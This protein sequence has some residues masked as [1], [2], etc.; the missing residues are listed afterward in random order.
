[1]TS[2]FS[3]IFLLHTNR[4]KFPQTLKD[5]THKQIKPCQPSLFYFLAH[6][7]A[8][9][10]EE[11]VVTSQLPDPVL[12]SVLLRASSVALE[13]LEH[14]LLSEKPSYSNLS[15]SPPS[16]VS[17]QI[18]FCYQYFAIFLTISPSLPTLRSQC[19]PDTMLSLDFFS[20]SLKMFSHV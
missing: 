12:F 13:A 15:T 19:L 1:M 18:T 4:S 16:S 9:I 6:H 17:P 10:L 11:V 7:W 5:K 2:L 3:G 20:L 14:A 8:K